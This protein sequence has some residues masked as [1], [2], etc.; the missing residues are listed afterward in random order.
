M[1]AAFGLAAIR[2][3]VAGALRLQG[4]PVHIVFVLAVSLLAA[5]ALVH[6]DARLAGGRVLRAEVLFIL[7]FG[8][9]SNNLL[10]AGFFSLDI[11]R[12]ELGRIWLNAFLV[13]ALFAALLVFLPGRG[14]D[15]ATPP[16]AAGRPAGWVGRL[17]LCDLA[18]VVVYFA[19]GIVVLPHVQGFYATR[20]LPSPSH[21]LLMQVPR[22]LVFAGLVLLLVR[23][24]AAPRGGA[25][26]TAG[27]VLS[28]LGGVVPLLLPNP[29]LPDPVR[30]AHLWEVG[31]SNFLFGMFAG[32][33]WAGSG[34]PVAA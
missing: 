7:P 12:G 24:R 17:V 4:P 16:S 22:G 3:L 20:A 13:D 30:L 5:A 19:A 11:P 6:V 14:G 26:L 23:R 15:P 8:I 10:E 2:A 21:V 1:L 28:I 29:Y 31:I 25:A 32:W 18:Y 33:L 27:L 9:E 34:R